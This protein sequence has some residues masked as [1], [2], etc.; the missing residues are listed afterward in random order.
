MALDYFSLGHPL[1]RLRSRYALRA[2]K[3]MLDCFIEAL[4]P[5]PTENVLDLGVTPD[6]TLEESNFFEAL[7]PYPHRIVAAS[8]EDASNIEKVFRGVRFVQIK[9][10]ELPFSDKQFDLLFCSAVLEHVG[11][12]AEQ[13]AF[14]N[15]AIRVSKR[16]MFTTPNRWFPIDF[17][18]LLPLIHWLP[19]SIHQRLLRITGHNFL[20][21]TSNLNLL[22]AR[23]IREIFPTNMRVVIR[24]IK[25]FGLT[26]N[27]VI[28]GSAR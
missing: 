20:A 27:L 22:G 7:Y 28:H 23:D 9:Q 11:T 19:Q 26:S 15:E 18:T 5:L 3:R 10:G 2:R 24:K 16:F 6:E 13:K 4:G 12:R 8:I 1:A 17:H 25:L 21:Q 14:V